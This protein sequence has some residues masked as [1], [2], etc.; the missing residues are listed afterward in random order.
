MKNLDAEKKWKAMLG[1]EQQT[2]YLWRDIIAENFGET[3]ARELNIIRGK[4]SG[5]ALGRFLLKQGANPDDLSTW[6]E[7]FNITQEIVDEKG[8]T[9]FEN[10]KLIIRTNECP[11]GKSAA[12]R[13]VKE[14]CVEGCDQ[15]CIV[16]AK[17]INPKV[18]C[19]TTHTFINDD[20]CEREFTLELEG[21]K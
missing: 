3:K 20:Y 12:K 11:T 7:P 19:K 16:M 5:E 13:G 14:S 6:V 9:R 15:V 18:K 8:W 4:K 1:I 21:K 17:T 10:G 2:K